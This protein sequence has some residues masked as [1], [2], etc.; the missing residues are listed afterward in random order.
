MK[1]FKT[2]V[3][4]L[5]PRKCVSCGALV[6]Q[7][8]YLCEYCNEMLDTINYSKICLRCGLDKKNCDC[9]SVV[10]HF[11]GCVAPFVNKDQAKEAMYRFKF[12]KNFSSAQFFANE[13][14]KTVKT[15][16]N[17]IV[18]DGIDFVPMVTRKQLKRGFNQSE[19][20]A[21]KLAEILNIKVYQN[22]LKAKYVSTTQHKLTLKERF[23]NV[24][25]MYSANYKVTGKTIL[26]VDDIKTTG[27]TLDECAKQLLLAGADNVY[28][29]SGVITN[30]KKGK[31]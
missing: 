16:Y 22:L 13:M 15:V 26:L 5:F 21:V 11:A 6:G 25:G 10:F 2:I 3:N 12:S 30:S 9:K 1:V 19:V 4:A 18:F 14:A 28:C 8:D 7:D 29:I 31:K 27:A 24:K 17:D 23:K 20:L